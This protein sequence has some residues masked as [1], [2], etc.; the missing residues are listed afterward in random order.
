MKNNCFPKQKEREEWY[1]FTLQRIS[2]IRDSRISS[3]L[4]P[5][6]YYNMLWL[7][8]LKKIQP[9]TVLWL[10]KYLN[11]LMKHFGKSLILHQNSSSSSFFK[12]S[13][14]VESE[15]I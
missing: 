3:L 12:I 13:H 4:T 14:D 7:K 8:C 6:V 2:S 15:T 11:S 9:H 1:C 5:S 10:E